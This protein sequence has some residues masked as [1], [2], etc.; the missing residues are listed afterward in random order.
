MS[1]APP[2]SFLVS[3]LNQQQIAESFRRFG[4][5]PST[6]NLLIIKVSTPSSPTTASEI[7]SHLTSS[8]EGEQVPFEDS[9][10]QEMTD[11]ARI[12]KIYKLNSGGGGGGKKNGQVNVTA[13]EG[14]S[15][16]GT[17]ENERKELGVLVLGAMAL[18][19]V[20]N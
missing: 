4:I 20:T 11:V 8:I 16:N 15:I 6:T 7:Q 13:I 17:K 14:V 18:R 2:S 19:G 9:I 10:L 3:F 5:T 1:S 12:K